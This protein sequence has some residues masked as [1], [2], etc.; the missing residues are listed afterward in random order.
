MWA[1]IINNVVI[2]ITDIDPTGRFHESLVWIQFE[3]NQQAVAQNW[4]YISGV[5]SEPEPE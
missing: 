5:F 1:L 4:R 3:T 2:E